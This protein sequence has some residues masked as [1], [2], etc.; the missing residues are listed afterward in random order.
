VITRKDTSAL[1]PSERSLRGNA[2][3]L[4]TLQMRGEARAKLADASLKK[5]SRI[6]RVQASFPDASRVP[7]SFPLIDIA[8]SFVSATG[9]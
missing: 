2:L 3:T 9:R 5:A 8:I 7:L 6:F 1:M 4:R